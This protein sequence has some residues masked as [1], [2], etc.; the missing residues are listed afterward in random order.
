[1]KIRSFLALEI[2]QTHRDQIEFCQQEW[3]K[4]LPP[5]RWAKPS[6]LHLTVKFLGD[7]EDARLDQFAGDLEV[8]VAEF[9]EIAVVFDRLGCF[10]S[11]K[12]ARV[13]W[14][15]GSAEG[16][17]ALVARIED[18]AEAIGFPREKRPW[19]MHLTVA[20][21]RRPWPASDAERFASWGNRLNFEPFFCREL[22]LFESD[23]RPSGAVYKA[24]A[25]FGLVGQ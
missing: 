9:G 17:D 19:S 24:R 16:V 23:L 8:A 4:E 11:P 7:V 15:G 3:R 20:R 18:V 5:A 14:I 6:N 10:P 25:R 12:R 22:V 21:L 2:P 13:A 1:M